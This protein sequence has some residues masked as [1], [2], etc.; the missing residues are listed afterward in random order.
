MI[1]EA[2]EGQDT[3]ITKT[4]VLHISHQTCLR[5]SNYGFWQNVMAAFK[6][7]SPVCCYNP[8][9]TCSNAGHWA[10]EVNGQ[11]LLHPVHVTNGGWREVT[12]TSTNTLTFLLYKSSI[13]NIRI[14]MNFLI[15]L[16]HYK[17]IFH[18]YMIHTMIHSIPYLA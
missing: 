3:L 5:I 17:I 2:T 10:Q 11:T 9:S 7:V 12:V 16:L 6:S 4:S 18:S 13:T 14:I 15:T 1:Q 8:A